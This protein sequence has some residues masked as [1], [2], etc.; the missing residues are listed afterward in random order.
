MGKTKSIARIVGWAGLTAAGALHAIW[1]SGSP[2]PARSSKQL[3]EAVVGSSTARPNAQATWVVAGT[4]FCGAAVAAGGL[5]EGRVAV[6]LRRLMGF[7]LCARAIAGGDVAV[8]A[9]QLPPAGKRFRKLDWRYYRPLFGLI[10][11]AIFSSAK[12]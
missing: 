9:L 5:G 2:W 3:S 6:R 12:K 10:G 1:A 7:G 11:L 8:K 4:A